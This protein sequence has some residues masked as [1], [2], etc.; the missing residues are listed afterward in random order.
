MVVIQDVIKAT[1]DAQKMYGSPDEPMMNSTTVTVV[2]VSYTHL[3]AHETL[4]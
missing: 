4:R 2:P 3:R 1:D